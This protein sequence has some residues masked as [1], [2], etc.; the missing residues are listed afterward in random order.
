MTDK[1]FRYLIVGSGNISRTY[2]NAIDKTPGLELAAMVS[3]SG[4]RAEN[5]PDDLPVFPSI[6]TVEVDFDAVILC[7]PNGLHHQ[8]AREAARRGK[9]V[10]TEK[11]LEISRENMDAMIRDCEAAGVKLA[12]SYQRRMS[13]ENQTLKGLLESGALGRIFAADMR[14]KFYRDEAYY[15]SGA[16]RGG[17]E[18]DG[19]GPFIQQAAHNVDLFCWFFG[20]PSKVVSMLGT[21]LHDIEVEDHGTALLRYENGMLGSITASSACKPGFSPVLEIHSAKGSVTLVNDEITTWEIEGVDNPSADKEFEVHSGANTAAVADTAGH[22]AIL[23]DFAEAVRTDREPAV[24][25]SSGR[26][27]T[28]LILQIYSANVE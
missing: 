19:G 8:G 2:V 15:N 23:A 24:P 17:Y 3:R 11:V 22:E 12:V 25:A 26:L 18:I 21:C 20:M 10:L 5:A 9:H 27:A 1:P 28:D 16:Y 13:P 4:K 7:T 6:E 14:V